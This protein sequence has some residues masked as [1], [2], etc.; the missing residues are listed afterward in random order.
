VGFWDPLPSGDLRKRIFFD[1]FSNNQDDRIL[2]NLINYFSAVKEKWPGA[3]NATGEGHI[4]P[5]TT[6]FNGLVRFLRPAYLEFTTVPAVVK[7][8]QFR[9]LFDKTNLKSE[10]FT[11][12]NYLPGS[13]G[14]A[15]LFSELVSQ[16]GVEGT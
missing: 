15:K 11:R 3:W 1:F 14:A 2:A 10:G 12:D 5:R 16:T 9:S 6:G 4:L 8:D 7:K 13:S